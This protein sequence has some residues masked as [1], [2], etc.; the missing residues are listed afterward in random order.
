MS[1]I[2]AP[3]F[4]S[5]GLPARNLLIEQSLPITAKARKWELLSDPE[6]LVREFTFANSESRNFFVTELLEYEATSNHHGEIRIKENSVT[7]AINTKVMKAITEL[8][9]EYKKQVDLIYKDSM[10]YERDEQF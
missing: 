6:E 7:V 5:N 10:E 2:M 9:I 3:Y 8:D 1:E 4:K